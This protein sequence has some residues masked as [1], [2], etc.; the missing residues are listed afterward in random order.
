MAVGRVLIG[1]AESLA[2][3]ESAFCLLDEGYEVV[4]FTRAGKRPALAASRSV[5]VHDVPAPEH[6]LAATVEAV[7]SLVEAVRPDAVLP[8]DDASLLICARLAGTVPAAVA[9][10]VGAA[11]Q[12][13]LDKREQFLAAAK[14]G[15]AVPETVA[16]D[17]EP[18]G[19]GPW[20]VKSGL[21]IVDDGRRLLRPAGAV[22]RDHGA[23][24]DLV[25]G[26]TGPAVVQPIVEG[27]GEGVFG[28]A[29][30]GELFAVSA[31][32]RVRMM[33]PRG[34]G[35]SACLSISV[36]PELV[37][38]IRAM[39][40]SVDWHGIFM[41]E[42]LRDRAGTAWFMEVNGRTWGSMALARRRGLPYPAWA[43]RAATEPGWRPPAAPEAPHLLC[44]HAGRE[45]VHL[46][47][48]LRGARGADRG[49]WPSRGA[50]LAAML[51]PRRGTRWYNVRRGEGRVFLRD[52]WQTVAAQLGRRA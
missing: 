1:F 14:A 38:P 50:T 7:R 51:K 49:R 30:G 31:H 4:A 35:S 11:A 34:S 23:V 12:F 10:P 46:A 15:L 26:M 19:P 5:V 32:R 6:D 13:A 2:A 52:T 44:R 29:S 8:L 42:L 45:L 36:D 41:V 22:A 18:V 16:G 20:M 3:I 37:E 24:A 33:N 47:A 27:V 21:A 25:A 9:G 40:A 39:L 17:D 43:A 28:F 48:V